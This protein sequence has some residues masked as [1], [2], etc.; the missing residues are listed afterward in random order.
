MSGIS[1]YTREQAAEALGMTVSGIDYLRRVGRKK[2]DGSRIKLTPVSR[3]KYQPNDV[4]LFKK[5]KTS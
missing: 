4:I 5:E 1:F 2:K 3:G